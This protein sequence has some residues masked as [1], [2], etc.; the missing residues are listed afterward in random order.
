VGSD[1]FR[2]LDIPL[3]AG[4]SF[5]DHD[6]ETSRGVVIVNQ[7]LADQLWPGQDPLTQ[8][9]SVKSPEGP[10]LDV[11]G[12]AKTSVYNLPGET[13]SP[14]L[15]L[16]SSQSYR[17][18]QTLHVHTEAEPSALVGTIR[19]EI[20]SRDPDMGLFDVRT[21][22]THLREGKAALLFQLGSGLVGSFGL[23]GLLLA[24]VG[25][26]GVMSYW[27]TQRVHD[28]GVRM[29]L[30]ATPR[31]VLGLVLRQGVTLA[32]IGIA[33]GLLGAFALTRSFANLLVGI[34][35]TDPLTFTFVS[36]LLALV[37]VGSAYVPARRAT[38]VD[39]MVA[40]QT[41]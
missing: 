31:D 33:L 40:L 23:I 17:G 32:A 8:R 19:A 7:V 38:G 21:M 29:A 4:R 39:P 15:Y 14:F 25:L 11:V 20:H 26:Y 27:V 16:P 24:C 12:V 41:E 5:T 22:R 37:A 35:P 36:L 1:Y 28:I 9:L 3:V 34:G 13:P 30:G 10:F 6:T 18:L 2:T